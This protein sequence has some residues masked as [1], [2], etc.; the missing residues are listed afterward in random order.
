MTLASARQDLTTVI[1]TEGVVR[2][3]RLALFV[4]LI[5]LWDGLPF[6]LVGLDRSLG[7][8]ATT[9]LMLVGIGMFTLR[10]LRGETKLDIWTLV[11]L[12]MFGAMLASTIVSSLYFF[13]NPIVTWIPALSNYSPVFLILFARVFDFR[14]SEL[15]AGILFVSILSSAIVFVDHFY[16]L[17]LLE[18]YVG[19][20]GFDRFN[21][22]ILMLKNDNAFGFM[23]ALARMTTA[24]TLNRILGYGAALA[25]IGFNIVIVTEAR[26]VVGAILVASGVYVL[27]ILPGQRRA[28]T[29]TAGILMMAIAGPIVFS[30]YIDRIASTSDYATDD[31]S[32][33]WRI[34]TVNHYQKYFV[35]SHYLGFGIMPTS[36]KNDNILTYS[37][38][39]ASKL[40]GDVGNFWGIYLAD[41]SLYGALYQFGFPGLFL[42]V[43]LSFF[44]FYRLIR[45]PRGATLYPYELKAL[46]LGAL[47]L[48]VSPWPLNFFGLSWSIMS[49][50]ELWAV[51]ARAA[52]VQTMFTQA[53]VKPTVRLNSIRARMRRFIRSNA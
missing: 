2:L 49:G 15:L 7:M 39:E 9:L 11:P 30:K 16:Q 24:R 47:F 25:L 34:I 28:L 37:Y 48:V 32:V 3:P 38:Y 6:A 21:R 26:L 19:T 52:Q 31:T 35:E 46:G 27:F 33:S 42:A 41:T 13:Y 10:L 14:L 23:I 4:A 53:G 8:H 45:A 17:P 50:Y 12:L 44:A 1:Q 20:S 18:Q 43:F 36:P 22:R 29:A 5:L 40:Y 51:A